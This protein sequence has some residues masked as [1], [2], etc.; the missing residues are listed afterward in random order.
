MEKVKLYTCENLTPVQR[1]KS[2]HQTGM[3]MNQ[4]S[5]IT[6]TLSFFLSRVL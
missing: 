1:I 6:G 2:R 5:F 4:G 3:Q